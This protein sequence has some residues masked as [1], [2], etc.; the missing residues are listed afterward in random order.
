M[1]QLCSRSGQFSLCERTVYGLPVGDHVKQAPC[2]KPTACCIGQPS[3][4]VQFISRSCL[5]NSVC[6]ARFK[7]NGQ[8]FG[9]RGPDHTCS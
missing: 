2:N 5:T 1:T 9:N 6:E 7:R 4:H 8:A 3:R